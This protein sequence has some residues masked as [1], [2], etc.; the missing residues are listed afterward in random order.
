MPVAGRCARRCV[1]RASAGRRHSASRVVV[2]GDGHVAYSAD[3]Q[4]WTTVGSDTDIL[5]TDLSA[6]VEAPDGGTWLGDY[7]AGVSVLANGP[8][9]TPALESV[10]VEAGRDGA[11]VDLQPLHLR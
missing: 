6:I 9:A 4:N 3:S 5:G 2:P 11:T 1:R 7:R 8:G 10:S